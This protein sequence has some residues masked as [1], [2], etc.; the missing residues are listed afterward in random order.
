M[1]SPGH[2]IRIS[3]KFNLF[4][5]GIHFSDSLDKQV[6]FRAID[7]QNKSPLSCQ[8]VVIT[9]TTTLPQKRLNF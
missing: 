1:I 2:K 5:N 8:K 7:A 4:L 3:N 6:N 9:E